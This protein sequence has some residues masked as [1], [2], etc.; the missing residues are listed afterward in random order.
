MCISTGERAANELL[1]KC[2]KVA[3]AVKVLSDGKIDYSCS[4]D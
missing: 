1:R 3:E 4:A 2:V